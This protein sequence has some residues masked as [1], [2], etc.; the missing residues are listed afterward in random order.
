MSEHVQQNY[1]QPHV[2]LI[3]LW[4]QTRRSGHKVKKGEMLP[5]SQGRQ[6]MCSHATNTVFASRSPVPCQ[7]LHSGP[8]LGKG[9]SNSTDN[10]FWFA[11]LNH[12]FL[13]LG[14]VSICGSA[15][16]ATIAK[17]QTTRHKA[18]DQVR[19]MRV[20][21]TFLHCTPLQETW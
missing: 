2:F 11:F 17:N 4:N 19:T 12:E 20:K 14:S 5:L 8:W 18:V 6:C 1:E 9:H 16:T 15:A 3:S 7:K 21:S 13:N 10:I